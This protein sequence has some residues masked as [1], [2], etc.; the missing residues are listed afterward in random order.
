[1]AQVAREWIFCCPTSFFS[2]IVL[3][4]FFCSAR[5]L[6][7]P[8]HSSLQPDV[9]DPLSCLS[10][11]RDLHFSR[12]LCRMDRPYMKKKDGFLMPSL[13]LSNSV[14][15]SRLPSFP[16]P[17]CSQLGE[18]PSPQSASFSP[19][20]SSQSI[21]DGLLTRAPL[22]PCLF[23]SMRPIQILSK[24]KVFVELV[25]LSTL[26]LFIGESDI[27]TLSADNPAYSKTP[28]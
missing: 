26:L 18:A 6:W 22:L 25:Q 7:L 24:K 11:T 5:D 2:R 23:S 4:T 10:Q 17:S 27:L 21:Q 8:P 9:E 12:D 28:F 14:S 3:R 13:L 19:I 15:A 1:L 20:S 16:A